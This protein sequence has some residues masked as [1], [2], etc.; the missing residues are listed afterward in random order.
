MLIEQLQ[1]VV[2]DAVGGTLGV[3][4]GASLL[5]ILEFLEF[6]LLKLITKATK[7]L[8]RRVNPMER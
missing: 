1:L 6:T 5:T 7:V 2:E 8:K 3:C 4:L